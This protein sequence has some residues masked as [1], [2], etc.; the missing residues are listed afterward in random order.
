MNPKRYPSRDGITFVKNVLIPMRDGVM[1]AADMHMPAGDG[2]FPLVLEYIPYRKDDQ[3]PYTGH[4]FEFAKHGYIGCRIDIRG[5]GA[6]EGV[7]YDEY[8]VQEQEDGYDA[9][10]W[11]AQQPWC[12]G[13]IAM[14]G[15]SYGGFV[16]YQVATHQPPHLKAIIPVDAT[17]D[18]YTDDCHYRGGL[19]RCYYDFAAYGAGMIARNALPPYPE[20]SGANWLEIW[21]HHLANNQPYMLTWI[22]HQTNDPYWKPGSLRGQY[23]KVQC[24]TFI[25]GGWRDGYMNTVLRTYAQLKDRVPTRVWMG[26]WDHNAPNNSVPGPRVNHIP[27]LA[28]WLDHHLKGID[29]GVQREPPI[30][31]FMQ[32]Y[33]PPLPA[34][35]MTSGTW[36]AEADWPVAD[37]ATHRLFLRKD[38][39]LG[40][41]AD[42]F[43]QEYE[44]HPAVGLTAGLWSAGVP[45]GLPADQRADE[46][47]SLVFTSP[48]LTQPVSILGWAHAHI[49]VS[50]TAEVMAF[51]ASLCDVAP[52]GTSALIAKGALNAT[53]RESLVNPTPL[54]PG[55]QYAL[56][57]EIDCTGWVFKPGH[58]IRVSIAS[59]DYPNLWPTP[60]AGRNTLHSSEEQPAHLT[61]PVVPNTSSLPA[62]KFEETAPPATNYPIRTDLPPWRVVWDVLNNRAGI[63]I[64]MEGRS[65]PH[66]HVELTSETHMRTSVSLIDPADT[67]A[68]GICRV[69]RI[70]PDMDI[71]VTGRMNIRSTVEAFHLI[72]ELN[73]LVDGQPHF[74]RRWTKTSP[75]I[76][77]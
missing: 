17:D 16:C 65:R 62:P 75:R 37:G 64:E 27:V 11:L 49:T 44:Y 35:T 12:T 67:G 41:A 4:H 9:I 26:P 14:Y 3:T 68:T 23:E 19:F 13:Q 28:R 45:F 5:T 7:N 1:L 31:V 73:V 34:R 51:T 24:A 10:E 69:R 25:I 33:D 77:L 43:T 70:T 66:P 47:Y 21:E 39:T 20:F 22:D 61:L 63:E 54:T 55:E 72:V 29:N 50:S 74:N 36:R 59:A 8:V 56:D 52:D 46:A 71:D 58:R 57:I 38:G 2:P 42:V 53:R 60:Y 48:S 15:I 30:Q 40:D 18:R 76:L 6:S 32:E